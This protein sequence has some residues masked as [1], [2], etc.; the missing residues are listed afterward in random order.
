M[1]RAPK[2]LASW[3]AV[4]PMPDEPPCTKN[5]SPIF[6]PPRSNTLCQTV[7]KVSGMAAASS[8]DSPLTGIAWLPCATQYSA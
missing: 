1:T 8:I 5:V 4:V 7:R 2:A 6:K 3:I